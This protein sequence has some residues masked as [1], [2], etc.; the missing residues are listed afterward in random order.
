MGKQGPWVPKYKIPPP[1][2]YNCPR[3]WVEEICLAI[4]R[5][6]RLIH[7]IPVPVDE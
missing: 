4:G 3:L 6:I 7:T 2:Q 5:M 1:P